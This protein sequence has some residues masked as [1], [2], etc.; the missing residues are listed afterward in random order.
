MHALGH[1]ALLAFCVFTGIVIG[2]HVERHQI[3]TFAEMM[4]TPGMAASGDAILATARR[5][6]IVAG[7]VVTL[8]GYLLGLAT[9]LMTARVQRLR[10]R[11]ER[12]AE[13]RI[14]GAIEILSAGVALFDREDRLVVANPAYRNMHAIIADVLVPG[15]RFET[16]LSENVRRSRFDLGPL[17]AE[18][19]IAR[20]LAQH[21][22][23]GP[24]I[25]RRLSDGRWEQVREQRLADGGISLVILDITAEKEREAALHRAKEAAESAN[26]AKTQF[27]A[28][29]SHELRTPLNAIIGF[30]EIVKLQIF[31]PNAAARYADYAKDI[32]DS[33]RHLLDVINDILDM[34]K[35]EAGRYTLEQQ[36]L[37]VADIGEACLRIVRGRAEDRRIA[38]TR[39]IEP[40]LPAI[41]GDP[42]ALKQVLLN[43]LANA[44][45][46]TPEGGRVTLGARAAGAEV[47]ISVID[48]GIGIPPDQLARVCEPFHQADSSLTRRHEGTGLG[49]SISRRLVEMHGGRLEI[50]S[51]QGQGTTV[52]VILPASR[53]AATLRSA[54]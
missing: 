21:R 18:A 51:V 1:G 34:S 6:A 2:H 19:Y 28:N 15:T 32:V 35:I 52:L 27:L 47:A 46:F 50:S 29:V 14:V 12:A 45:K 49:L 26:R 33:A 43:L 40:G 39:A 36:E 31:G 20:R 5:D 16:I 25:E 17:E 54:A 38:I 42:R 4:G 53:S 3:E 9:F 7:S 23:P 37:S 48:T 8:G 30:G 11:L 10:L 41:H 24:P 13:D 22:N 44:I